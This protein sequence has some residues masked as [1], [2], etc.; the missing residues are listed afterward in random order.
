MALRSFLFALRTLQYQVIQ[1]NCI[2]LLRLARFMRLKPRRRPRQA[3]QRSP[4]S[5]R[6]DAGRAEP[7]NCRLSDTCRIRVSCEI[8]TVYRVQPQRRRRRTMGNQLSAQ[9]NRRVGRAL[10]CGALLVYGC[11]RIPAAAQPAAP[12]AQ[13]LQKLRQ[14]VRHLEAQQ[15]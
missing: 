1:K 15:P 14:D 4:V 10:V 5:A 2:A 12:H 13:E 6:P 9:D 3:A 7:A 8:L 11:L